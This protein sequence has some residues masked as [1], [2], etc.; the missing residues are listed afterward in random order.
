MKLVFN[1]STQ[2]F[3]FRQLHSPTLHSLISEMGCIHLSSPRSISWDK[4][5][6]EIVYLR[7]DFRKHWGGGEWGNETRRGQKPIKMCDWADNHCEQLRF[8]SPKL[9]WDRTWLWVAPLEEEEVGV[10]IPQLPSV[11]GQGLLPEMLTL[12]YAWFAPSKS[13][14]RAFSRVTDACSRT[15]YTRS[16]MVCAQWRCAEHFLPEVCIRSSSKTETSQ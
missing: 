4:S 2:L 3:D 7:D 13:K 12:Q 1:S 9:L 16:G 5:C 15:P 8:K 10:F 6:S 14:D 11:N